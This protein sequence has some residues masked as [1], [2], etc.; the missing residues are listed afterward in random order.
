MAATIEETPTSATFVLTVGLI[1]TLKQEAAKRK[2]SVS[3]LVRDLLKDAVEKE[4]VA[5]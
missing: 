4:P 3:E 2:V 1:F 5:A